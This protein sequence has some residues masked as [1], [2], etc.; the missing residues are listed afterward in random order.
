[1]GLISQD[2]TIDIP[3]DKYTLWIKIE[4][5][6]DRDDPLRRMV[7]D[8]KEPQKVFRFYAYINHF[9]DESTIWLATY[10][11]VDNLRK[12]R[13]ALYGSL[14]DG[15]TRYSFPKDEN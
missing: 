6:Y 13:N 3:Y 15:K 7:H 12:A 4:D 11:T 14:N 9:E 5:D 10:T 8:N 2:G 1:M